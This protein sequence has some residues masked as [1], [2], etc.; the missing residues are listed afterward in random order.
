MGIVM[1]ASATLLL[2]V[3]A[4]VFVRYVFPDPPPRWQVWLSERKRRLLSKR[5]GRSVDDPDPFVVLQ[6]QNRLTALSGQI[7]YLED[8]RNVSARAHRLSAA[9]AAYDD[10]LDEACRMAGVDVAAAPGEGQERRWT[11]EQALAERGWSW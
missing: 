7:R 4:I 2:F 11:E 9:Q 10:L 6:L 8:A 5:H 3:A 1:I